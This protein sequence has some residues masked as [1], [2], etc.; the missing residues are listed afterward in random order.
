MKITIGMGSCGKLK[1]EPLKVW[2]LPI[3]WLLDDDV[4]LGVT[5]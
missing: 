2:A 4:L 5:F 1:Q 3:L